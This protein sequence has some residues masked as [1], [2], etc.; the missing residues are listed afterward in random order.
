MIWQSNHNTNNYTLVC[1]GE[2]MLF[3]KDLP[4]KSPAWM[5][6]VRG[7]LRKLD[8]EDG[9]YPENILIKQFQNPKEYAISEI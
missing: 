2:N 9:E 7:S 5:G 3:T 8:D 6:M 4:Q 1:Q